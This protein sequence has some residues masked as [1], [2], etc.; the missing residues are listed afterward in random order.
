[1]LCVPCNELDWGSVRATLTSL[2]F[3]LLKYLSLQNSKASKGASARQKAHFARVQQNLRNG[4][5]KKKSPAK[6]SIFDTIVEE[7]EK[8]RRESSVRQA[9]QE[10]SR[11]RSES[12]QSQYDTQAHKRS[13][14]KQEPSRTTSQAYKL[15]GDFQRLPTAIEVTPEP[16]R[17]PDDDLYNA[18]PPRKP[19]SIRTEYIPVLA[20]ENFEA[21]DEL[22]A[23]KRRRILR[24]GD[25][26]GVTM[27]RPLGFSFASPSREE[28]IGKRRKLSDGHRARYESRQSHV[29]SPFTRQERY[30]TIPSFEE[31]QPR[32]LDSK[33]ANVKI[34][35]GGKVVPPGISSSS[36]SQS[37]RLRSLSEVTHISNTS[38]EASSEVMLLG[39]GSTPA[40]RSHIFNVKRAQ[41]TSHGLAHCAN[42]K[43]EDLAA[44]SF[45][46]VSENQ[47]VGHV[48]QPYNFE[49]YKGRTPVDSLDD[50]E[51]G[52]ELVIEA[53]S[54]KPGGGPVT[55]GGA[56]FPIDAEMTSGLAT[57]FNPK[58]YPE[59]SISSSSV[60]LRHPIPQSSK[61]F[62]L[63]RNLI[64][65]GSS[66]FANSTA[67][68]VGKIYPVVSSSEMEHDEAWRTW[69]GSVDN[70]GRQ[71]NND[72]RISISPGISTAAVIRPPT[73]TIGSEVDEDYSKTGASGLNKEALEDLSNRPWSRDP[74]KSSGRTN[75]EIGA[76]WVEAETT[77]FVSVSLHQNEFVARSTPMVILSETTPPLPKVMDEDEIWRNFVF[78]NDSDVDDEARVD[79][80]HCR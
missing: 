17:I 22:M 43:L 38:R 49:N 25:W 44:R 60:S 62:I 7:R 73:S 20:T 52:D 42:S 29:S 58:V 24:K 53:K 59:Y 61:S 56:R 21:Q 67:A 41:V 5:A 9:S 14:V 28:N 76:S 10:K 2:S 77:S 46:F 55:S 23:E 32:R 54:G 65:S 35:I 6:W 80:A 27:Q 78:G 13:P 39:T 75:A 18:T 19:A 8:E 15:S 1:M 69:F 66:E 16:A 74:S 71:Q 45:G 11:E 40:R 30:V 64:R 57:G 31:R 50:L 47:E 3:G 36:V 79:S 4:A 33:R 72:Q 48:E 70:K 68:Q 26:V 37:C 63:Q 34:S 12:L 51:Y